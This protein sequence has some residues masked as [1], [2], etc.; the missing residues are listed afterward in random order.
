MFPSDDICKKS[1]SQVKKAPS[2]DK[3]KEKR[4]YTTTAFPKD[5]LKEALTIA[6]SIQDII[7]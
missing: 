5:T 3:D 1:L 2:K 7:G 4:K 6:Q